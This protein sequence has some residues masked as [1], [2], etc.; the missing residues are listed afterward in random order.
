[1]R[2]KSITIYDTVP[3]LTFSVEKV[4]YY[5][6]F[7]I[8]VLVY[9]P[10]NE[11]M[12]YEWT[13]SDHAVS[14]SIDN[15]KSSAER[16]TLF[17]NHVGQEEIKL[18]LIVGD[19]EY[20]VSK[21]FTVADVAVRS[22]VL[23]ATD[24]HLY[25]QRIFKNGV[26]APTLLSGE[27]FKH[28]YAMSVYNGVLYIFDA[29]T[30]VE[31]S[32][33][34]DMSRA[35]GRIVAI[36]LTTEVTETM[37]SF[38][39]HPRYAP[40]SGL[41]RNNHLY[42]CDY[43]DY[44]YRSPLDI[45]NEKFQWHG[46]DQMDYAYYLIQVA[47]LGYY[48]QGMDKGQPTGGLAL[49]ADTYFWAK[50]GTGSGIYRFTDADILSGKL[51]DAGHILQDY[52]V[53]YFSLDAVNGKIYFSSDAPSDKMGLWVANLDGSHVRRITENVTGYVLVDNQSD[54]L[55]FIDEGGVKFCRLARTEANIINGE[56]V[57]FSDMQAYSLAIDPQ[58]R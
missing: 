9:N 25:R 41:V 17:Y 22:L 44:I 3:T 46:N 34:T 48:G 52:S 28:P 35:D 53:A 33:W 57:L 43:D 37:F 12:S 38:T 36:D 58:L 32:E 50:K 1:M 15:G 26:E 8:S 11:K 23:A 29:G 55:F 49:Y 54:G 27:T 30:A 2:T 21:T 10:D 20:H 56:P 31:P 47:R 18:K 6:S 40:Y 19:I 39:E 24:G 45:R 51:P 4:A 16:I 5:E 14:D 13:F 42:W 7:T